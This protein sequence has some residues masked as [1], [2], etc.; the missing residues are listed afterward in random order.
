MNRNRSGW[1]F[2]SGMLAVLM[3]PGA[4]GAGEGRPPARFIVSA[5]RYERTDTPVTAELEKSNLAGRVHLVEVKGNERIT[6]PC[7]FE[8]TVPARLSWILSG[9]TAANAERVFELWPGEEKAEART[10]LKQDEKALEVR[11]GENPILSYNYAVIP[12]PPGKDKLYER[13]GFIHPLRSASGVVLTQIHVPDH[14]HHMGLWNAWTSTE[15]E[16]RHVDFWNLKDGKGTVRFV[17]FADKAEGPVYASFKA[18]Q[19]HVDLSAPGGEK[20]ALHEIQEVRVWNVG[21]PGKYWLID[22]VSTQKCASSS[23]LKLPPY[24]YG[25]IGFRAISEW[26]KGNSNY[27]TSEGKDRT[28]GH[29]T[30]AKWCLAYGETSKGPAGI[31]FMSHPQNRE[32]PE[33]MRLWPEGPIFFNFCPVQKTE[34]VLEPGKEY[35]LRYRLCVYDG[36]MTAEQAERLWRD[37]GEAPKVSVAAP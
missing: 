15:F 25:G 31:E 3:L 4:V 24:R 30:R 37:F 26:D 21:G 27:L 9:T 7:Q 28:N 14:I 35:V 29:A 22:I 6:V 12:P 18:A 1:F 36:R 34:W 16:G 20:I 17:K 2:V 33:P 23:P 10:G 8:M 5:G 13:S 32:H 19:D 11:F